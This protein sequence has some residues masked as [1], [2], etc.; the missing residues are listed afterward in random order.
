[1]GIEFRVKRRVKDKGFQEE[2]ES[3]EKGIQEAGT[4][5]KLE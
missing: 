3:R 5:W 2:K 4:F 1:M